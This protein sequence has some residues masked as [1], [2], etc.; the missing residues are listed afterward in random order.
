MGLAVAILADGTA[1]DDLVAGADSI[2][3]HER[4]GEATTY[5]IRYPIDE[6]DDD[7]PLLIDGRL[8]PGASLTI[9][10]PAPEDPDVLVKGQVY[11]Q[12]VRFKHNVTGSYLDILGG[13]LTLEMDRELVAKIWPASSAVSDAV[14]GIIGN[15]DSVT[16]DVETL[17]ITTADNG[18]LLVQRDTDLRFVRRLS[19][20]YGYW[21]WVTTDTEDV[22]TAHWKRPPLDDDPAAALILNADANNVDVLDL[23]WDVERPNT[24]F[25]AQLGVRDL[26]AI[27]GD[28]DRSPLTP[29]GKTPLSELTEPRGIQVIAPADTAADSRARAEG[30]LIESGWFIRA[31][32]QTSMR[33]LGACLHA[34]TLV[35]ANG[36]GTRHSGT[37]VV[38]GVRHVIDNDAHLMHFELVR[39]AWGG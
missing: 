20:R 18:H 21:F 7:F 1:A 2:E 4:I 38:A 26:A 14:T 15:Y 5:R 33:Q 16:P 34:H 37:Y 19:R 27:A 9:A 11:G 31:R 10:V 36:I 12:Q 24:A 8:D 35:T 25:A 32:G 29:L 17:S 28:V 13:D 22:T 39:N 23:E 30:A 3:V 6:A